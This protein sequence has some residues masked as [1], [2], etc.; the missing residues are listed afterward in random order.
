MCCPCI[1]V[2]KSTA[3]FRQREYHEASLTAFQAYKHFYT[4]Q[5]VP[6][7]AEQKDVEAALQKMEPKAAQD[8][9][10]QQPPCLHWLLSTLALLLHTLWQQGLASGHIHPF[11]FLLMLSLGFELCACELAC[12]NSYNSC[13]CAASKTVTGLG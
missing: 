1:P 11:A 12:W 6:L 10:V 8:A 13:A 9:E 2:L 7:L 4:D 5:V 3:G